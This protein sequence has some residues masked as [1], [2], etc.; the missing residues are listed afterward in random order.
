MADYETTKF[1]VKLDR[2]A[3]VEAI[4]REVIPALEDR[5]Y[6]PVSQ[7]VG[8]FLSGDPTYITSHQGARVAMRRME[9]DELL[10]VILK[11]YLERHL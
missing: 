5:G 7:L 10:E 9:R 4:L 2:S 6:Q 11:D 8:Y 1:E 3:Q